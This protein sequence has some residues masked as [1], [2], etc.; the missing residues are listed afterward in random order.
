TNYKYE[1]SGDDKKAIVL[2]KMLSTALKGYS[3]TVALIGPAGADKTSQAVVCEHKTAGQDPQPASVSD[4]EV[5]CNDPM[6]SI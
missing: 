6:Q 1:L 4:T 5:K 3:G 2:G